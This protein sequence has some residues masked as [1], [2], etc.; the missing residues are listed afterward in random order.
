MLNLLESWGELWLAA[1]VVQL[2]HTLCIMHVIARAILYID[3]ILDTDDT[4]IVGNL[5]P[6]L[7][8]N[9]YHSVHDVSL[10]LVGHFYLVEL[11]LSPASLI[12]AP[13]TRSAEFHMHAPI[14]IQ[15]RSL[16]QRALAFSCQRSLQSTCLSCTGVLCLSYKLRRSFAKLHRDATPYA[17]AKVQN[18]LD[19]RQCC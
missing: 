4:A 15:A 6:S 5:H 18:F 17:T 1:R 2:L 3:S 14:L 13:N 16:F 11:E 7:E 19:S 10:Q 8:N 9:T 12:Y